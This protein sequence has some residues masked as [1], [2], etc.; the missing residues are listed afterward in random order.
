MHMGALATV[1]RYPAPN[2]LH[3]VLDNQAHD[4]VGGLATASANV[5]VPAVARAC[6]YRQVSS[7]RT[8]EQIVAALTPRGRLEGP[9][10]LHLRVARGARAAL[11]R[12]DRSPRDLRAAFSDGLDGA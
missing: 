1:G 5:D 6:G 4:S 10:L 8:V 11:G 3:V 7:A 9:S 12:P 2:L